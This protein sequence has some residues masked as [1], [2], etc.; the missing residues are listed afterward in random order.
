MSLPEFAEK[1]CQLSKVRSI[2]LCGSDDI[3]PLLAQVLRISDLERLKGFRRGLGFE[4]AI[5]LV[6]DRRRVQIQRQL[7]DFIGQMEEAAS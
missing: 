1:A 6:E 3:G 5:E 7:D 4:Y 2:M